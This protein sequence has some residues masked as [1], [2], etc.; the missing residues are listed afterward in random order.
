MNGH[1]ARQS[2]VEILLNGGKSQAYRELSS[3][4]LF[5]CTRIHGPNEPEIGFLTSFR[6]RVLYTDAARPR[7]PRSSWFSAVGGFVKPD[8]SYPIVFEKR[9][10][11]GD[12]R[13][14]SSLRFL[15]RARTSTSACLPRHARRARRCGAPARAPPRSKHPRFPPGSRQPCLRARRRCRRRRSRPGRSRMTPWRAFCTLWRA[16]WRPSQD[17]RR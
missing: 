12:P 8:L 17:R 7:R 14:S 13:V 16:G 9:D 5:R 15:L 4:L 6:W 3:E 10:L 1:H 11:C 2:L